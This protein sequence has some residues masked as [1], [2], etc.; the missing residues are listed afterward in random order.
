MVC[1]LGGVS[2]L[3]QMGCGQE[4]KWNVISRGAAVFFQHFWNPDMSQRDHR[5]QP[6][7]LAHQPG[8]IAVLDVPDIGL[9]IPCHMN[10][11]MYDPLPED[12]LSDLILPQAGE[13]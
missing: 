5:F 7:C 2:D 10:L 3:R 4:A 6:C 1:R 11:V 12:T 9:V 13:R 8:D